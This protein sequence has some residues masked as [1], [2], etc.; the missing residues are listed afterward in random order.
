[1]TIELENNK[2]YTHN[3]NLKVPRNRTFTINQDKIINKPSPTQTY[4]TRY[5]SRP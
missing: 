1:M 5:D 4:D 3:G 2:C